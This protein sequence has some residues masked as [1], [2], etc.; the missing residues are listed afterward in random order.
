VS[1]N[2]AHEEQ[3]PSMD[4]VLLQQIPAILICKNSFVRAGIRHILNGTRFI[5]AEQL[6]SSSKPPA[7][8]DAS[9]ALYI[10]Q[11]SYSADALVN[12]VADLKAQCPMAR[13]VVLA[14]HLD[15]TTMMRG[16]H[17][18]IDGLCSTRIDR[19]PLI[20]V[21][22]LVMLGETFIPAALALKMLN[23]PPRPYENRQNMT[24]VLTPAP[25]TVADAHNLSSREVEIL[26]HLMEGESNKV[27]AARLHIAEATI[28]V[29]VKTILRKL[30]ANNRTQAAMWASAHLSTA[31]DSM[32]ITSGRQ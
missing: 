2:P 27:M 8:P 30:R 19:D 25:N 13:V 17:A 5:V 9:P 21:L 10:L 4:Q 24:P 26:R 6:E 7:F 15:P 28:K 1:Q 16:L 23:H 18:G 3:L 29:H 22:E 14:D 20:K 12:L 31:P 11:G 32:Y